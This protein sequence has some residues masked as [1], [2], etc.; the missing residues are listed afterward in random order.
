MQ[1]YLFIHPTLSQITE[2]HSK[3]SYNYSF[4]SDCIVHSYR[5]N[6]YVYIRCSTEFYVN[7]IVH[8]TSK[9]V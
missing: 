1:F 4:L 6:N 3:F 8:K 7:I 9:T 2:E 5:E